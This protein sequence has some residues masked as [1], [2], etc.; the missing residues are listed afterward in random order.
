[1]PL[2][3]VLQQNP[4]AQKPLMHWSAAVHAVPPPSLAMQ[5]G[6]LQ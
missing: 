3:A 1:V 2:Q 5:L 4:F 6:L